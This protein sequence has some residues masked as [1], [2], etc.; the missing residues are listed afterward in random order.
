VEEKKKERKKKK[1]TKH[2]T[3]GWQERWPEC[4]RG[5]QEVNEW[6]RQVG[7]STLTRACAWWKLGASESSKVQS[8]P[9]QGRRSR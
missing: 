2:T 1:K 6:G 3:D 4:R 8:K 5:V 9:E 7:N